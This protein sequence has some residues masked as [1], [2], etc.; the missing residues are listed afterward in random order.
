M[1]IILEEAERPGDLH[2][3]A[4][5]EIQNREPSVREVLIDVDAGVCALAEFLITYDHEIKM[6]WTLSQGWFEQ[7]IA[8]LKEAALDGVG[9]V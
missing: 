3:I 1:A 4:T 2:R 5:V 9:S 7:E 8:K 6:G